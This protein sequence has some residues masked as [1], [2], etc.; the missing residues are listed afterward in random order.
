M[1]LVW[2]DDHGSNN[3][4]SDPFGIAL[5]QYHRTRKATLHYTRD[6]GWTGSDN[7]WWYFTSF[8]DFPKI[9]KQALKHVRG[10]VLDVGCGAGRH[11][12][13]LQRKGFKVSGLDTSARAVQ[14]ARLRGARDLRIG[15]VCRTLP[16]DDGEFDTILLFG[17][18]LG[19]GGTR[20]GTLGLFREL[21]RITR[22][23]ARILATSRAPNLTVPIHL[24]YW[25][26]KTAEGGELGSATYQIEFQGVT[27]QINHFWISPDNLLILAREAGWELKRVFQEKSAEE[28]YAAVLERGEYRTARAKTR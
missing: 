6:D 11:L 28:G 13:Y 26:N 16:F 19:L 5:E 25:T 7:L 20:N 15:S 2:R 1:C 23:G 24:R 12:L 10:R 27:R 4:M 3:E 21:Y 8:R 14:I 18:N 9:E 17:N 22:R